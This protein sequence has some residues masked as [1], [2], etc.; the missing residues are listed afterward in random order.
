M[1]IMN[2]MHIVTKQPFAQVCEGLL[3]LQG[4]RL[5]PKDIKAGAE[6]TQE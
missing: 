6:I 2:K 3:R 1:V 5:R 4:E